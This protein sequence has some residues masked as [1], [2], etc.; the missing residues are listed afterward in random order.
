MIMSSSVGNS[1]I[2]SSK[3]NVHFS[4]IKLTSNDTLNKS[5]ESNQYLLDPEEFKQLQSSLDQEPSAKSPDHPEKEDWGFDNPFKPGGRLWREAETIVRLIREGKPI[6]PVPS[7]PA[8]VIKSQSDNF[9]LHHANHRSEFTS[10]V[11]QMN[12]DD[13]DDDYDGEDGVKIGSSSSPSNSSS[14]PKSSSS[15]NQR[16]ELKRNGNNNKD[17]VNNSKSSHNNSPQSLNNKSQVSSNGVK[18][19]NQTSLSPNKIKT[20][21]KNKK[22]GPKVRLFSCCQRPPRDNHEDNYID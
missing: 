12:D 9:G 19:I 10:D 17:L 15:P 3:R 18:L 14:S 21:K 1:S 2:G 22:D 4:D 8:T 11:N 7:S 6:Y 5:M 13:Y 20:T 16:T